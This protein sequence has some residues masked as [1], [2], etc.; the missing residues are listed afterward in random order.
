MRDRLIDS[1]TEDEVLKLHS[2][3][4]D[5][6]MESDSEHGVF[7]AV[8]Y[9]KYLKHK[10]LDNLNYTLFL[11]LL[12]HENE[13]VIIALLG[14]GIVFKQF[15][16][17]QRTKFLISACFELLRRFIPGKVFEMTLETLLN[18]FKQHYRNAPVGYKL[19]PLSLD[20]V[21]YIGKYLDKT[22][23]QSDKMN[24]I[25]LDILSDLGELNSKDTKDQ[26]IDRIGAHAN[27]IRSAFLDNKAVLEEAIP[28]G[29]MARET[30]V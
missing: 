27:R 15:N 4:V 23:S 13:E 24:R 1:W 6:F 3:I 19:Y 5:S 22:K 18:V 16:K 26:R 20:E 11:D 28:A 17:L 8:E 29:V 25:I 7:A 2:D 14:D 21:N 30:R 9:A 12:L 10:G